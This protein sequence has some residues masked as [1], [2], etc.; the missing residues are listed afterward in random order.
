MSDSPFGKLKTSS[1]S[2]GASGMPIEL[3]TAFLNEF[4]RLPDK[5]AWLFDYTPAC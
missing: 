2:N 5:L 3:A 1:E 4:Q